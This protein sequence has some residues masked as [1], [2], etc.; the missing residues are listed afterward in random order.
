MNNVVNRP[1]VYKRVFE[2]GFILLLLGI[3]F[4]KYFEL[5]PF[6]IQADDVGAGSGATAMSLTPIPVETDLS[7]QR[8]G[9]N[10]KHAVAR[11]KP[12]ERSLPNAPSRV[13]PVR[14]KSEDP[15]SPSFKSS[16]S[17]QRPNILLQLPL[18][19][20]VET[21]KKFKEVNGRA[22]S[23]TTGSANTS[24]K[25]QKPIFSNIPQN[26]T[27]YKRRL[28]MARYSPSAIFA[29]GL[30]SPSNPLVPEARE[31]AQTLNVNRA[32]KPLEL[33]SKLMYGGARLTQLDGTRFEADGEVFKGKG[34]PQDHFL[35]F[36]W[37]IDCCS[38]DAQPFGVIVRS[39]KLSDA[40]SSF[41]VHVA[42]TM[43]FQMAG[44][45]KIAYIDAE[46]VQTIPE[47]PPAKRYIT[48]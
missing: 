42:G 14:L 9:E 10:R 30:P 25:R 39:N 47:P 27:T 6:S 19:K 32:S 46:T 33:Y 44:S 3:A 38:V 12:A 18:P 21:S 43:R 7:R 5:G 1:N 45:K 17:K 29:D 40:Q 15:N 34:V 13:K 23:V 4:A 26:H 11:D 16:N 24:S 8:V 35:L 36:R 28:L 37:F 31:V 2:Y 20:Q 41:W 22:K 48:Y